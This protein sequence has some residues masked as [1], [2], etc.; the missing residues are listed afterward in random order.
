MSR[1]SASEVERV[2]AKLEQWFGIKGAKE[3]RE[4]AEM[5][6]QLSH[7]PE[8]LPLV[9]G[10]ESEAWGP[11][12]QVLLKWEQAY[13]AGDDMLFDMDQEVLTAFQAWRQERGIPSLAEQQAAAVVE[14]QSQ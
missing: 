13:E 11:L 9:Q 1:P 2:A 5:L 6:R 12:L 14:L 10:A 4:G 3:L 7:V 8:Q